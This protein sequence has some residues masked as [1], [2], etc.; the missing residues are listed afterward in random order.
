MFTTFD[1]VARCAVFGFVI[2]AFVFAVYFIYNTAKDWHDDLTLEDLRARWNRF[3][4][5]RR[6]NG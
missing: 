2:V 5:D 4:E 6:R 3:Y 1:F